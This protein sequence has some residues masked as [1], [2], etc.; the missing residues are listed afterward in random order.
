MPLY[1]NLLI[2]EI[3]IVVA[4]NAA[5]VAACPYVLRHDDALHAMLSTYVFAPSQLGRPPSP[6]P[7]LIYVLASLLEKCIGSYQWAFF[8]IQ[9]AS[10]SLLTWAVY[11]CG[12]T[13]FTPT[14]GFIAATLTIIS[15]QSLAAMRT[16]YLD[17]PLAALLMCQYLVYLQSHH[18]QRR[19]AI[20]AFCTLTP[21][22]ALTKYTFVIMVL[23]MYCGIFLQLLLMRTKP[24]CTSSSPSNLKC[25]IKFA[26]TMIGVLAAIGIVHL[27]ANSPRLGEYA[28]SNYLNPFHLIPSLSANSFL[29]STWLRGYLV[30]LKVAVLG[31]ILF[32]LY[33]PG[34][35]L[36]WLWPARRRQL[37]PVLLTTLIASLFL[38][39]FTHNVMR[40]QAP[41]FGFRCLLAAYWLEYLKGYKW[42]P[43]VIAAGLGLVTQAGWLTPLP[44]DQVSP[45]IM[46]H[47]LKTHALTT[48]HAYSLQR[49]DHPH[50]RM[51]LTLNRIN[52]LG[53][54][55]N[56]RS[57]WSPSPFF[58][59]VPE[60]ADWPQFVQDI[61]ALV[62]DQTVVALQL[63][64]DHRS[65]EQFEISESIEMEHMLNG[66]LAIGPTKARVHFN[67][68]YNQIARAKY[69]LDLRLNPG[70]KCPP[71]TANSHQLYYW[72]TPLVQATLWRK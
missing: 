41:L 53:T 6:H 59:I 35:L 17:Y 38:A 19:G 50:G 21:L 7:Y 23:P 4:L 49:T 34:C 15:C 39:I 11:K 43:V 22:L 55:F 14:T 72:E 37:L 16:F 32:W 68:D 62:P 44:I 12:R 64:S 54:L 61:N 63:A 67:S 36:A 31:P 69:V 65:G 45:N 13:L 8:C 20:L 9:A 26:L 25:S 10:C 56:W 42:I 71:P 3:L 70:P 29:I 27:L 28:S 18:W 58:T 47:E 51:R 48:G 46:Q 1:R 30:E 33:L 40:Y 5:W 60:V 57:A 2:A 24:T 52:H 66:M